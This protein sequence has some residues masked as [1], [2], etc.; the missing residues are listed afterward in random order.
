MKKQ[1][2]KVH[3]SR[4][5]AGS[6]NWLRTTS[7]WIRIPLAVLLIIV[8]IVVPFIGIWMMLAG[9]VLVAQDVPPLRAPLARLEAWIA[10]WHLR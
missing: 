10:N 6:I 8:G 5:G 3:A 7:P 1:E 9:L 2:L 4:Y